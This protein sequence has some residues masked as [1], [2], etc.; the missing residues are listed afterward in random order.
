MSKYHVTYFYLVS[1][2][3]GKANTKDYGHVEAESA[4]AAKEKVALREA[5]GDATLAGWIKACL[6]ADNLENQNG[7]KNAE[8]ARKITN[9]TLELRKLQEEA[10]ERVAVAAGNG[11]HLGSVMLFGHSHGSMP[12]YGRSMDVGWDAVGGRILPLDEVMEH[13]LAKEIETE[14]KH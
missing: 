12:E 11:S 3:E 2:K 7:S 4:D 6:T 5:D 13:L 9:R 10:L 14:D 1:G 8:D